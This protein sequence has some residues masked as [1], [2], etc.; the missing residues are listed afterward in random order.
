[1]EKTVLLKFY[2]RGDARTIY[3]TD[4]TYEFNSST[5]G[6]WRVDDSGRVQI[7][8]KESWVNLVYSEENQAVLD[9]LTDYYLLED[10]DV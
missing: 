3:Y 5:L 1:M 4:G 8:F 6:H 7:G 10:S 2:N 9:A